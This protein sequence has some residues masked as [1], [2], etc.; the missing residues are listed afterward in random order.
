MAGR[1]RCYSGTPCI[2]NGYTTNG[3]L[4]IPQKD[5]LLA[6]QEL[7]SNKF[8]LLETICSSS[9]LLYETL[10]HIFF[11]FFDSIFDTKIVLYCSC[12]G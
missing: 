1:S 9:L 12:V 4:G 11:Q 10:F 2:K 8:A 5:V 6:G 3:H 7:F